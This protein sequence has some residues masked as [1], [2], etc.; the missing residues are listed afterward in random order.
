MNAVLL[1]HKPDRYGP[2]P[3]DRL[4]RIAA[5][6]LILVPSIVLALGN[7]P[8][9]ANTP[10]QVTGFG[11]N[12][13]NLAMFKYVP[14][15]LPAN[16]PLV[17]ALHGCSQAANAYDD[18]TGW[19][20][21]ADKHGFAL[22]LPQ[23]QENVFKCFRWFEAGHIERD[24]GE[25]LSIR[26]MIEKMKADHQIDPQRIFITGL[27][28]GGGM[29]AVMMAAYP[30]V[31]AGGAVIAGIPY[32]CATTGNDATKCGVGVFGQLGQLAP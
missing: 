21:F 27:S 20:K 17:V 22:L 9:P 6:V 29:T 13:G 3:I 18:E 10:T 19:V 23:A 8:A 5:Y 12:P 25:A 2:S 26:Q 7:R 31:F 24:Q 4:L 14:A 16:R 32:K 1:P 28:A 11:Q 30:E 15:N